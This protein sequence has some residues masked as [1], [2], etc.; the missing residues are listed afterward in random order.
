MEHSSARSGKI[1]LSNCTLLNH[2]PLTLI[3]LCSIYQR[4]AG[5]LPPPPKPKRKRKVKT[6]EDDDKDWKPTASTKRAAMSLA[7]KENP[8]RKKA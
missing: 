3:L 6:E 5:K 1:T 7:R 2:S 4:G 8:K